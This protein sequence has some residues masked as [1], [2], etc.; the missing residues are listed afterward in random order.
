MRLI[1]L[2]A[3]GAALALAGCAANPSAGEESGVVLSKE[4]AQVVEKKGD[5]TTAAEAESAAARNSDLVCERVQRTGSRM[6][7]RVCYTKREA[8]RQRDMAQEQMRRE[9]QGAPRSGDN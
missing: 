1:A 5:E 2:T 9:T 7:E 8:D 6:S 4:A 3:V